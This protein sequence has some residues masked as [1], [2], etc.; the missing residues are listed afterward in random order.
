MTGRWTRILIGLIALTPLIACGPASPSTTQA[1]TPVARDLATLAS[2]VSLAASPVSAKVAATPEPI[3]LPTNA[4]LP[5]AEAAIVA[6]ALLVQGQNG[7][8]PHPL[9]ASLLRLQDELDMEA[10]GGTQRLAPVDP[11]TP[12]W[13]VAFDQVHFDFSC[14]PNPGQPCADAQADVV[15]DAL[16]GASLGTFGPLER[17]LDAIVPRPTLEPQW[18]HRVV[19]TESDGVVIGY[20]PT[21]KREVYRLQ[22]GADPDA[23]L[24]ADERQLFTAGGDTLVAL[25]SGPGK[26]HWRITV[27]N[28]LRQ[29]DGPPALAVSP[30]GRQLYL[31]SGDENRAWVQVFDAA[32]G[33]KL[34][35]TAPYPACPVQLFAAPDNGTL[36]LVCRGDPT[37]HMI[38]LQTGRLL[39]DVL[40]APGPVAG[41]LAVRVG[42]GGFIDIVTTDGKGVSLNLQ[43]RQ[44]VHRTELAGLD[45]D[46][47]RVADGQVAGSDDAMYWI[48]GVVPVDQPSA[49][50]RQIRLYD[51]STGA[52]WKR[53]DSP[54]PLTGATLAYEMGFGPT[55]ID[56]VAPSG[57]GSMAL[58][59]DL[60]GTIAKPM[61]ITPST[62][63][64]QILP[65]SPASVQLT[66]GDGPITFPTSA[67]VRTRDEAAA[68]AQDDA[69]G[70]VVDVRLLTECTFNAEQAQQGNQ[71]PI[72]VSPDTPV[73]IVELDGAH[74]SMPCASPSPCILTH[75]FIAINSVIGLPGQY[76]GTIESPLATPDAS[77]P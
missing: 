64:R 71:G 36:F 63:I 43:T 48:V 25:G 53:V 75:V 39:D 74:L 61:L 69:G 76:W 26:E 32:D 65:L 42:Q 13:R 40:T 20:D 7:Q 73:W 18:E 8:Q 23:A 24:S 31:A 62:T 51:R 47:L 3:V 6:A 22:L 70:T 4:A 58:L 30:D 52:E 60:S 44:V 66:C 5:T 34:A 2:N 10:A 21:R 29:A 38:D 19:V 14:L 1:T 27:A 41:A 55:A 35:D 67:Q 50:T 17:R 28:R 33:H 68:I 59:L 56:A 72:E 16:T 15:L 49:G 11:A 57:D 45:N 77:A 9:G 54:V 46:H 37:I 12:V